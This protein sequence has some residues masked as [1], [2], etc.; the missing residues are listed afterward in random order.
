VRGKRE[1]VSAKGVFKNRKCIWPKT[2]SACGL[3]GPSE[4]GGSLWR[5][6]GPAWPGWAG[7]IESQRKIKWELIFEFQQIWKFDKTLRNSTR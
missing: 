2:A 4:G 6:G 7:W 3:S 5:E 1:T